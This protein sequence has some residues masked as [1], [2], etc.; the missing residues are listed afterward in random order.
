MYETILIPT[1]GSEHATR[2]VDEG[3]ELATAVGATV[4][5]L[6]AVEPI[7]LGGAIAGATAASREWS[8]VIDRQYEAGEETT[9]A[10]A[11]AA[12]AADL[13]TVEAI[14]HGKPT[15]EILAYVAENDIDAVVMGTHG[16]SGANRVLVG[17][18]TEQVVRQSPVP[19]LTIRTGV[20]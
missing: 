10:V 6:F 7:P 13:E 5:V 14:R 3:L 9:A 1:D 11:D 19:V 8:D 18:V 2:A 4:H 12:R 17:S 15:D 20:E 16:R